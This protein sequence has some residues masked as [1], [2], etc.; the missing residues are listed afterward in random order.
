ML[1][2]LAE[3]PG[4]VNGT[5]VGVEDYRGCLLLFLSH[6]QF[7]LFQAMEIRLVAAGYTGR[8]VRQDLVVESIQQDRPF[9]L[10]SFM[11][12]D[13]HVRYHDFQGALRSPAAVDSVRKLH[14]LFSWFPISVLSRFR[15][16]PGSLAALMRQIVRE[17][18]AGLGKNI[19]RQ[20]VI[21]M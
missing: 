20:A 15:T 19:S 17:F 18:P 4:G 3:G 6:K 8:L 5:L 1:V 16:Y 13:C 7:Q 10:D 2:G 14:A 9:P 12:Q 11:F 21:T